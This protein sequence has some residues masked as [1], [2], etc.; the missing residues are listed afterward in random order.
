MSVHGQ[1]S[2]P[3]P[4]AAQFIP[5][6][7]EP[8]EIGPEEIAGPAVA[9][10]VSP[11]TEIG[12]AFSGNKPQA[13]P[14]TP[15]YAMVFR[16]ERAG[17][18]SGFALGDLAFCMVGHRSWVRTPAAGA[19]KVPP[20]LD[21]ADAALARLA[22][23]SWSTLVT[24]AARP[25]EAVAV[26]GLGIVGHFA[27]QI[28]HAA[29]YR[30]VAADPVAA[31]RE[32]LADLGIEPRVRQP[33]DDDA[34]RGRVDLV[35][36]CSGHEAAVLDGIH[37]VRKGGEVAMVGVPWAKRTDIDAHAILHAVFHQY[38]RLRSGWEWEVPRQVTE[39]THGSIRSNIAGALDWLARGRLRTSGCYRLVDPRQPQ[40]VYEELMGQGATLTA[41]YDWSLL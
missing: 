24:T 41:V 29:G 35:V 14:A 7:I 25:P 6:T 21:P 11:G 9:S 3:A 8:D 18:D 36:E 2:I 33:L 40:A 27:A 17:A 30:V 28:F 38:A 10:A 32:L 23:V 26:T 20:G 34:W 1:I 16:V 4:Q 5:L 15:G 19:W 31:R 22:A 39:F 12:F 13:L 37:L